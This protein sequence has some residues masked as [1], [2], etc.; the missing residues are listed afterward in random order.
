MRNGLKVMVSHRSGETN[1]DY[2]A[3]LAVG[4]A[5]NQIKSGSLSRSERISKYNRL[6]KIEEKS[7]YKLSN[8]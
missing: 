8:F 1:D 4:I 7:N 5:A 6:M 2:I 3:D